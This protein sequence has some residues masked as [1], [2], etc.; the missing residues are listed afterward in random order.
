[1]KEKL[2]KIHFKNMLIV[3]LIILLVSVTL[4]ALDKEK[5]SIKEREPEKVV[6]GYDKGEMLENFSKNDAVKAFEEILQSIENDPQD[7]KRELKDRIS[8]LDKEE[9]DL[10]DVISEKTMEKVYLQEEFEADKFNRR[11]VASALLTYYD[12]ISRFNENEKIESV[13][14]EESIDSLVYLDKKLMK[15]HIPMDV[16]TGESRGIAFE[17]QYI[18]GEWYYNPYTSMMSLIMLVNYENQKNK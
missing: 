6:V 12:V 7:S 3:L 1:M 18:D 10:K 9:T 5:S 15:A 16:F 17:M 13:M 2:K 14:N 11:F 4:A 8:A